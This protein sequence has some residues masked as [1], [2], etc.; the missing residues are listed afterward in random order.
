MGQYGYLEKDAT[1][2]A[3]LNTGGFS[4]FQLA[5][6]WWITSEYIYEAPDNGSCAQHERSTAD[7]NS[8]NHPGWAA[9][10]IAYVS[11]RFENCSF[12]WSG[13]NSNP[14]CNERQ[15]RIIDVNNTYSGSFDDLITDNPSGADNLVGSFTVQAGANNL[16]LD[17][18]WLS[19][20]GTA[21]EGS[22]IPNDGIKIYFEAITGTET[23]NGNESSRILYGDYNSNSTTNEIWGN[24]DLNIP[25]TPAG[26]RC[27]VVVSDL[28]VGFLN[29]NTVQFNVINDGIS[30]QETLDGYNLMRVNAFATAPSAVPLPVDWLS[31]QASAQR[32]GVELFWQTSAESNNILFEVERSRDGVNWAK[33][34]QKMPEIAAS[35]GHRGYFFT[36]AQPARQN[37]YRIKQ[38]DQDGQF[39]YSKV[40]QIRYQTDQ[41]PLILPNPVAGSQIL[42]QLPAEQTFNRIQVFSTLGVLLKSWENQQQTSDQIEL[43]ISDLPAG[44]YWFQVD[45]LMPIKLFRS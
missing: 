15:F 33:I 20:T 17:R 45:A 13:C 43:D 41:A 23:Y 31:F 12:I 44:I 7:F 24:N 40:V 16:T 21:Q 25:I 2:Y 9:G 22:D 11:V 32:D 36:D 14:G 27:Y 10:V 42:I 35:A 8:N 28:A 30:L 6:R 26:L 29:G 5:A 1:T 3:R 19:N 38:I 34:G 37:Y 39:S 4:A 18:L